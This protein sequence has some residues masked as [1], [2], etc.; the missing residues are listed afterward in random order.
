MS[1]TPTVPVN[2]STSELDNLY[3]ISH[4]INRENHWKPALDK[5]VP[6]IR[7]VFIFDNLVLY[8]PDTNSDT[9]EAAYARVIGRG[10]SSGGDIS[11]GEVVAN[12]VFGSG[13]P[14]I[15]QPPGEGTEEDRLNLPYLLGIP[16]QVKEKVIGAMVFIRFGGPEYTN[17][18]VRVASFIAEEISHLMHLQEL[19]KQIASMRAE[20]QQ[21]RLQED[22]ISTISHELLTPLGFIKGYTTTLLRPDT[23]W[24]ENN[25]YEFLNIIDEETDRLQELIDNMLDSARLQSGT[26]RID[27]QPVRLDAMVKDVIIRARTHHKNLQVEL[28]MESP[29]FAIEGDPSRLAQVFENL[30][31]NAVKYAPGSVVYITLRKEADRVHLTFQDNG[32]G[33]PAKYLPHLFERFFR[34]PEQAPNVRGTGLGLFICRQ[35]IEAHH[36]N[37]SVESYLGEGTLFHIYLPIKQSAQ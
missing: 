30:I 9:L 22:F 28:D 15:Q 23:T 2:I 31:S 33:I 12:Q 4:A 35:I 37:I 29:V 13:N 24:D 5:M 25:Q 14:S 36:G 17:E 11:W 6:L 3:A 32:P 7:A 19:Q 21:A 16:L 27:F 26:L 10:R 1:K 8:L 20:Q 18:N 34:N